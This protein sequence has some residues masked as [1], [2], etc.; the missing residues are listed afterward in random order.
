MITIAIRT[1]LPSPCRRHAPENCSQLLI[2]RSGYYS[3]RVVP[4]RCDQTTKLVLDINRIYISA[5]GVFNRPQNTPN[6]TRIQ[7]DMGVYHSCIQQLQEAIMAT[8]LC[9]AK[10][11]IEKFNSQLT[12]LEYCPK[13]SVIIVHDIYTCLPLLGTGS[14]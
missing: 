12:T 13:I 11:I 8:R 9:F 7:V 10:S 4:S 5:S 6:Y 14:K 1:V 2:Y 3:L